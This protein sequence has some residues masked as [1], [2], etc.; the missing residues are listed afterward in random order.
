MT[1]KR[2][3]LPQGSDPRE[4]L[5]R[6]LRLASTQKSPRISLALGENAGREGYRIGAGVDDIRHRPNGTL[7]MFRILGTDP[8]PAPERATPDEAAILPFALL[9]FGYAFQG[10]AA[11]LGWTINLE[12]GWTDVGLVFGAGIRGYRLV[13]R[14]SVNGSTS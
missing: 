2:I 9:L 8:L 7:A 6:R 4:T 14:A 11:V 1:T 13:S 10:E 12:R 3:P 5:A